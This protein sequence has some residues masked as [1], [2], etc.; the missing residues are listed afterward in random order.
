MVITKCCIILKILANQK[1]L[2]NWRIVLI[3]THKNQAGINS[4]DDLA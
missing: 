3:E 2:P 1:K 4:N